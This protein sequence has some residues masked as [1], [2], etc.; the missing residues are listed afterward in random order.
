MRLDVNKLS[1][2]VRLALSLGA[3]AMTGS[4]TA[5]A[6]DTSTPRREKAS[7]SKPSW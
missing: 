7:P 6:Q 2:A 5:M 4:V 3:V 1:A